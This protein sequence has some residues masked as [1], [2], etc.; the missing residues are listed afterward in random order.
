MSLLQSQMQQASNPPTQ[1]SSMINQVSTSQI[2]SKSSV[3]GS[4]SDATN[5]VCSSLDQFTT[6]KSVSPVCVKLPD[7]SQIVFNITGSIV[8]F[9]KKVTQRKIGY[10]KEKHGLYELQ[11]QAQFHQTVINAVVD[12]FLSRHF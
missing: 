7:G 4:D 1:Q 9:R 6:Y 3:S 5:H 11:G 12:D 2:S 8:I 10:G